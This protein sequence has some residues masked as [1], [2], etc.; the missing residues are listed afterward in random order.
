M[1]LEIIT[2]LK[3]FLILALMTISYASLEYFFNWNYSR[4]PAQGF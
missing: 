4:M 3:L 2:V 1:F